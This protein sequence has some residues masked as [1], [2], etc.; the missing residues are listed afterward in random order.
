MKKQ[1]IKVLVISA[2]PDDEVVCAGTLMK[3]QERGS[4]IYE[5]VLTGGSEGGSQKEREK[6]MRKAAD[7]LGMKKVYFLRQEDL[8]LT[9]SKK[10]MF[11]VLKVIRQVRPELVFLMH[12]DDFHPDHREAF[13]IG[14]EAV[15]YAATGVRQDFGGLHRTK[16]VLMMGGMWPIRPDLMVDVSEQKERKLKMFTLHESQ[17]TNKAINFETA[18]MTIYGYQHRTGENILAEPFE[19]CKEFPSSG[20]IDL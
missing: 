4:E 20:L 3:L 5:L 6:E 13:K 9:Y 18:M 10:L 12:K 1:K 19:F 17:A 15:K 11:K 2:H 14:I 8:G 7:F 16:M